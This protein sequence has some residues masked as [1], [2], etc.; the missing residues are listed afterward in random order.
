MKSHVLVAMLLGLFSLAVAQAEVPAGK[1]LQK[2]AE[3]K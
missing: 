2:I 3:Q 1:E